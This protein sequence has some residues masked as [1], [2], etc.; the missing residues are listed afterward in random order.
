MTSDAKQS[1]TDQP[2]TE[3]AAF[4]APATPAAPLPH[5]DVAGSADRTH[6]RIGPYEL[7]RRLGAGAF[8]EVWL[9]IREG[10]IANTQ[11][12]LKLPHPSRINLEAISQEARLWAQ[13]CNHP[14]IVPIFEANI[15]HGQIVIASEYCA[16]GSLADWLTRHGGKAPTLEVAVEIMLG[17]L[18]G[19]QHLHELG[20]VHRDIKPA[21]VLLH[22]GVPRLADFGMSRFITPE[23]QTSQ[24]GGTPAFMAP[25]A[26]DGVR[27][28]A[29]D[30]W[31]VGVLCQLLLTAELPFPERE[32]TSLFKAIITREPPPLP[33]TVPEPVQAAVRLSLEKVPDRRLASASQMAKMLRDA[34]GWSGASAHP[35]RLA[36]HVATFVPSTRFAL[37]INATNLSQALEREITHIW[38][39][40]DPKIHVIN[41]KRPLPKRLKP[42]ETWETW[43]DLWQLPRE[44]LNDRL[45]TSVR[46]RLSTGEIISAV[47][48]ED[49]PQQGFVPGG[50]SSQA[51]DIDPKPKDS[52]PRPDSKQRPWW[53]IW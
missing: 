27:S 15:Y 32:W 45:H 40:S 16:D 34:R 6:E 1:T 36:V 10:G 50:S 17:I 13:A 29:T 42:Q 25:E 43:I 5:R 26:F 44:I 3:T 53:K 20:I 4:V 2:P 23:S 22:K 46:A 11:L 35:I 52:L 12:A 49:V 30:I 33:D 51:R 9:A 41:D 8:G 38:I 37:F 19:L 39:D 14:N 21:N 47:L 28:P 7:R 48:N 18:S 31:S 24:V